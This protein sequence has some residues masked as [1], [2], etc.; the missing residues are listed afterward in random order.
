[1]VGNFKLQGKSWN[2]GGETVGGGAQIDTGKEPWA[3]F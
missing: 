3:T 1:M 2:A